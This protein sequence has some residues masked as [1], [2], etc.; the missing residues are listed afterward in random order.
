MDNGP[1]MLQP[2]M[3]ERRSKQLR[4]ISIVN[5]DGLELAVFED[6]RAAYAATIRRVVWIREQRAVEFGVDGIAERR[7]EGR[8]AVRVRGHGG[9]DD[10]G[11][12]WLEK[13]TQKE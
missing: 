1:P 6:Y 13:E 5:R 7:R 10:E 4:N 3:P 11:I 2:L 12:G 9:V 8:R